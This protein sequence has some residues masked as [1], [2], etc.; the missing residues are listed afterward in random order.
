MIM[1]SSNYQDS[2]Y[3]YVTLSHLMALSNVL[4]VWTVPLKGLFRKK[5]RQSAFVVYVCTFN[6]TTCLLC[7]MFNFVVIVLEWVFINYRKLHWNC[8]YYFLKSPLIKIKFDIPMPKNEI[9]F[10]PRRLNVIQLHTI[11]ASQAS[12]M[13]QTFF[14][15]VIIFVINDFIF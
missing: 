5:F 7:H 1:I 4:S 11:K 12:L 14:V 13:T 6:D 9:H 8:N 3:L 2:L 15:D 10:I